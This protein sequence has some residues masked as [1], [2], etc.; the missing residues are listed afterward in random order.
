[1]TATSQTIVDLIWD[2]HVVDSTDNG[3]DLL[4]I[5]RNLL[6]DLSGT[7]G[8]GEVEAAKRSVRYPQHHL[9]MPDHMI[10]TG[11]KSPADDHRHD[12]FVEPLR[13]RSEHAGIH[14]VGRDSQW[15]GIVHVTGLERGFSMPGLTV[16]CG[17][18]HT[19]THGAV[20]ALAW[21][22]GSTDV[23][24][25]LATQTL[26]MRRP[27][28][29]QVTT[30]GPLPAGTSAKDVALFGIATLG[31]DFGNDRSVEWT[32]EAVS[33]MTVEERATLCNLGVELGAR[34]SIIA[35]DDI[36]FA[37]LATTALAPKGARFDEA[38]FAWKR[39]RSD[40]DAFSVRVSLDIA[41]LE[42]MVTWGT[43]PAEAVNVTGC[44]PTD[45]S[46]TSL[47]YM[48][49][50]RDQPLA[51]V[52][53]SHVFI[54]SCA[55]G[56]L[57][58][59]RIAAEILRGRTISPHVRTL[60]VPGSELVKLQAEREGLAEV[61]IAAGCEWRL[62]GCSMCVGINGDFVPE[63]EHCVSTSNRNFVGRQG[64][65][66][67]THLASPATAAA[68]A[69]TGKITDPRSIMSRS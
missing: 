22:I 2:A 53:I 26:W 33:S 60:V 21:G 13:V 42:P 61:F 68:S 19:S 39:L 41:Q 18:S 9:A 38:V 65:G 64:I 58:D 16:V 56:R 36:T 52:K 47:A 62:P 11:T 63:G 12:H 5:D 8:L 35:P 28:P 31:A 4:F 48:G 32:G 67:R 14:H 40:D 54:G 49:L 45:A 23:A 29:A 59:L 1:M 10:E 69:I 3:T 51:E 30:L 7:L 66:A 17:D 6:T 34:I 15:Q 43:S 57:S 44:I 20:G 55:N 37:Y 24:H 27:A 25:V 46:S 50:H